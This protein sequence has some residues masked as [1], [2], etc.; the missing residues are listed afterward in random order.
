MAAFI[1]DD[2]LDAALGVLNDATVLHITS[3]ACTTYA[4][5]GTYTL[6]NKSTPTFGSITD[7]DVSGQVR[8]PATQRVTHPCTDARPHE[9]VTTGVD[10]PHRLTVRLTFCVHAANH[11]QRI[12]LLSHLWQQAAHPEP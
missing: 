10:H 11:A 4:N 5:V 6:G 2:A 8:M 7:G 9:V 12:R 3:Q 1:H